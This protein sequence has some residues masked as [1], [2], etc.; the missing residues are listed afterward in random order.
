ME[1][2][3]LLILSFCFLN[4]SGLTFGAESDWALVQPLSS[5][6]L[7]QQFKPV[8]FT[9]C[10]GAWTT[11]EQWT[12][13][14]SVTVKEDD[15]VILPCS[16]STNENVK[17]ML[18]DWQKEGTPTQK[19]VFLY[20]DGKYYNNGLLG[21]DKEFKDRVSHFPEE[22]SHGNASI[23]I[24]K[25]RLEDNGTYS[26]KFPD[27]KQETKIK[28]VVEPVLKVRING[29]AQPSVT[30]LDQTS[31]WALLQ[32]DVQSGYP[33][34]T[35]E[36]QNSNNQTIHSEEPHVSEIGNRFYISLNTT[37]KKDDHYRCIATQK[38]IWHQSHKKIY[39]RLNE[40]WK[41]VA[42]VL[43]VVL[44]V[45]LAL[46]VFWILLRCYIKNKKKTQQGAGTPL[47]PGTETQC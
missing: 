10:S 18:F 21:Q 36:W 41:I 2:P 9:P 13:D 15:D 27:L 31:D 8:T 5:S 16:L 35:V 20:D 22:L 14:I 37:V 12:P 29:V 33:K 42:I 38:E 6:S 30:I 34:P 47:S 28:L 40:P 25:T 3:P 32:C 19:N 17:K 44:A 23:R 26:C 24:K 1:L 4:L 11:E 7:K 45:V 46:V 39:I 43:A